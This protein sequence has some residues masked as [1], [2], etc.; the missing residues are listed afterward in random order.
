MANNPK[1]NAL[2]SDMQEMHRKKNEDYA[3]AENPYSNF[4]QAGE[5]AKGFT[6]PVD[7]AFAALIGVK[8]ARLKELKGKGK[9]PNNE[10]VR[11]T[12]LDLAVYAALWA[13]YDYPVTPPQ[14][15]S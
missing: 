4:E 12:Q 1:F 6:D 2:M 9:V 15:S 3:S 5:V 7:I 8:L 14:G 10:S 13:S 11:D